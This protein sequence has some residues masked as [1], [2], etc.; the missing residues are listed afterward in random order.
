MTEDDDLVGLG[1]VVIT[2]PARQVNYAVEVTITNET[3]G[4]VAVSAFD[5]Q[6]RHELQQTF[7]REVDDVFGHLPAQK[8]LV[9]STVI[10]SA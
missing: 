9:R 5:P 7:K 4:T 3:D 1:Q 6:A 2:L 10:N 8:A